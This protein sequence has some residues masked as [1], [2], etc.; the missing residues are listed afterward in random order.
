MAERNPKIAVYRVLKVIR[1]CAMFQVALGFAQL[2]PGQFARIPGQRFQPSAKGTMDRSFHRRVRNQMP[3]VL[4]ASE[5]FL[6]A[7]SVANLQECFDKL[8]R[9][10]PRTFSRRSV[11]MA[12]I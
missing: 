12:P 2:F 7:G 8:G 9:Y 4:F 3:G 1:R 11:Q 10:G 6:F 5:A